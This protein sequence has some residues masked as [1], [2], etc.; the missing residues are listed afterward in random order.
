MLAAGNH[1]AIHHHEAR[2]DLLQGNWSDEGRAQ[3]C[4]TALVLRAVRWIH[5][6]D[7]RGVMSIYV[8]CLTR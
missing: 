7:Y 6:G 8:K 3:L 2:G 5:G 1:V 4:S